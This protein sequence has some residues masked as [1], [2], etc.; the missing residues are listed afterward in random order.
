[1]FTNVS[2]LERWLGPDKVLEISSGMRGWH[3]A[4]ISLHGVPGNVHVT[5]DGNFIGECAA[6]WETS[7]VD[8]GQDI[9]RRLKRAIKVASI[10]RATTL[11]AGLTSLSDIVAEACAGKRQE[12]LFYKAGVAGTT[13]NHH[14][15]WTAAGQPVAG[16]IGTAIPA[17]RQCTQTITGALRLN[18]TADDLFIQCASS[19]SA[20]AGGTLLL[21]DRLWDG[22]FNMNS[23]AVQS[24]TGTLV[25]HQGVNNPGNIG[26]KGLSDSNFA[27]VETITTLANTAHNITLNYQ[28]QTDTARANLDSGIAACIANRLDHAS[29]FFR[30]GFS[31][32]RPTGIQL[33][34]AVATGTADLV[35][36]H[37]L[38]WIAHLL[39]LQVCIHDNVNT[40]FNMRT[41]DSGTCLSFLEPFKS[42][43]AANTFTGTI[44]TVSG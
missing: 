42:A 34:D 22:S 36:G 24:I 44:V 43:A 10:G 18:Y 9:C 27:F 33:S 14:T 39:A 15:L 32:S 19:F 35:V 13:G 5:G 41:V 3:G 6:G 30:T 8:R 16:S 37:P 12:S 17:G 31:V 23:T 26:T 7:F 38:T 1:V 20:N 25:R 2:R 28:D 40:A 21:Y 11:H 29:W 4:P